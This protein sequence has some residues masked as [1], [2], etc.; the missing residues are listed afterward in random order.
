MNERPAFF[1][2]RRLTLERLEERALLDVT[3]L[4]AEQSPFAGDTWAAENVGAEDH[5]LSEM[6][7][8]PADVTPPA[9]YVPGELLIKLAEPAK[10]GKSSARQTDFIG[11]PEATESLAGLLSV[12]ATSWMEPVFPNLT[13]TDPPPESSAKGDAAS[14]DNSTPDV[15]R[16]ELARWHRVDLSEKTSVEDAIALF[17]AVPEVEIAEAN[18]QWHTADLSNLPDATTDPGFDE[19]WHHV[20]A[21]VTDTWNYL[22][23]NGVNPGGM[24]DVIV[25]VIDTG[26]DY[27]HQDLVANMWTNAGEIPDNGIDDDGNGFV[28]DVHGANVVSDPRSHSGDP[29]DLHGH[30]THV[31]GIVASTAFNELGGVGVAFNTQIMAVRAAQYSGTFAVDDIAE[32]VIY[33]IDNG[34]E[35]INMSFGGYHNSVIV[36]DALSI[37]FSRAVLVAAA[38]NSG[39]ETEYAPNVP[40]LPHYPAALPWVLGVM[41]SDS[42]GKLA[43]FSN[44]D[45]APETR[46]EYEVAAPG[47]GIYST[48]PSDRYAAWSGTS[49]ATPVVAGIAALVRSQFRDRAVYSSRFVMGQIAAN[50]DGPLGGGPGGPAPVVDAYAALTQFPSPKISLLE[51]WVFDDSAIDQ[52]NDGDGRIDAGETIHLALELMGRWGMA[53]EVT[54]TLEA[55]AGVVG[56]DPYITMIVDT[57]DF[58]A[59]GPFQTADN[60][61]IYNDEGVIVGVENPLSFSV[62]TDCPNDHVIPFVLTLTYNNAW[63]PED[64]TLYERTF[65]FSYVVQR[66]RDVPT[67]ISE[68]MELTSDDYWLIGGPVLIE[69]GATLSIR[70]GT[71][72][73][74]GGISDDPYNPGPQNGNLLVRGTLLVEGT[75]ENPVSLFPSYLVAGQVTRITVEEGA[76]GTL[77]Y[78]KVRNPEVTGFAEIDHSYFD[79]DA[80]S[81]TITA[82]LITNTIFHKLRGGAHIEAIWFDG[83]LFD[84]GWEGPREGAELYNTVFLQDNE[85]YEPFA[86]PM[87]F[88]PPLSADWQE[89]DNVQ[90]GVSIRE[91]ESFAWLSLADSTSTVAE[92]AA[93]HLG[94]HLASIRSA[95]EQQF[96][97]DFLQGGGERMHWVIGMTDDQQ[98]GTYEWLDGSPVTYT[99]WAPGYPVEL[100]STGQHLVSFASLDQGRD[101]A[102]QFQWT[103]MLEQPGIQNPWGDPQEGN[104]YLLRIPGEWTRE[105]IR[106]A[107][108]DETLI[109]QTREHHYS[110]VAQNAFLSRLWDPNL[111][112]WMRILGRA[113]SH[114]GFSTMRDNYWGTTSTT[115]ISHA[116]LDY[117]DN[118]TSA[119]IDYEAPL[120]HAVETTYPFAEQV[121]INGAPAETVPTLGA[122]PATFTVQFN[123]DMNTSIEPFVTFGPW[124][125]Y[126]DFLLDPDSGGWVDPRTWEATF[127]VNPMTGDG[128]HLMRV[129]GAVAADDPWLVT[130]YDVG[131]FRFEVETMGVAAMTLQAT[132]QEGSIGL[133]WQQDDFELLAG[134]H[135]YRAESIDGPY[136]RVNESIIPVGEEGYLDTDVTPAVP[137]YYKFTVVTTDLN[138]SDPSNVAAAAALDTILPVIGHAPATSAAAGYSLR[139]T[140]EVTD[141]VSVQSVELHYRPLGSADDYTTMAMV[142]VSGSDYSAVI[143]GSAVQTPGVDYYLTASDGISIVYDGTPAVPHGVQVDDQPTVLSVTPNQGS[144]S[145]GTHVSVSGSLFQDGAAVYF[146]GQPA[147]DVAFL[148]SSQITC[149][150]PSHFPALV[151]VTVVNP[152]ETQAARISGFRYV[153]EDAVMS[154]PEGSGDFGAFVELPLSLS[155]ADG[156]RAASATINFDPGVLSLA[157]DGITTGT[158][159]FGW[160][161]EANTATPG[162]II[163]SMASGTA[164]SGDGSLARINFEVVGAPTSQTP[165]TLADVSLNTGAITCNLDD[166]SFTVNGMFTVSGS[167]NYFGGGTVPGTMLSLAG[168][169]IHQDVSGEFGEFSMTD[170]L[171]GHYTLTPTKD[172]DAVEITSHDASLVL[173]SD[174]GMLGL[175]A[176]QMLAADVDRNGLVDA[177][178]ASYILEVAVA[179]RELPFPGAGRIWDFVPPQRSYGLI[180]SDLVGQDFTGVLIGD[181]SGNWAPGGGK[182]SGP[183]RGT[184]KGTATLTLPEIESR[185]GRRV[186]MPLQIDLGGAEVYSAD[187]VLTYDAEALSVQEVS[188]GTAAAGTSFLAN[189]QETGVIRVGLAAAQPLS[190]DGS[191]LEISFDVVGTLQDAAEVA[192]QT[193]RLNEDPVDAVQNGAVVAAGPPAVVRRRVFYNHSVFDDDDPNLNEHD[194]DA[195][196]TDKEALLPGDTATF[197]NY[198]SYSRGING[199][200]VDIAYPAAT[201]T[202]AD[203]GFRVGND[204]GPADWSEIEVESTPR[205]DVRAGE[206]DD[207]SDRV[208]IVWDD[209]V[210]Q[211]EWLQVTVLANENTGLAEDDVFYFGNAIGESGNSAIDAK[212]N[213]VD[214]VL[215][216]NNPRALLDEAPIDFCYDYNRDRRVNATDMLLARENQTH[217]LDALKLI[218]VPGANAK[219]RMTNDEEG[220]SLFLY[221]IEEVIADRRER[222][223]SS[224]AAEDIDKLLDV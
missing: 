99:N 123:R 144:Y 166:G 137:M 140:A 39:V 96:V 111:D 107:L 30:G 211:N 113:G 35:V 14:G 75:A 68:D 26:V 66:G 19:Q 102:Y 172:D 54:G 139:L 126:T 55:R 128:Y 167:M 206:G 85:L 134:Y 56:P 92:L 130:G 52:F 12:Y 171:T 32:G 151:D 204:N 179:L 202:A 194:N 221:E 132:G 112:H 41:A 2:S 150:T 143:P 40:K 37:A 16:A 76:T 175:S 89:L 38:G 28:D 71:Q 6:F 121:L 69:E 215:A 43:G 182:R 20:K 77:R 219:A 120:E 174:A 7:A 133:A 104:H 9:S 34:A 80:Y 197:A 46:Y 212:I 135:L 51:N 210:I 45:S 207:N 58:G 214:I 217:L 201:P 49:M 165:L 119:R 203:F 146:D 159:T 127:N 60:G 122:G 199:I 224:A 145:G 208:T 48:L 8:G 91:G 187:L 164:V 62:V 141:N 25:A 11:P 173:Q 23:D 109:A 149:T 95:E 216:R 90:P 78:T 74:W 161:L 170:V 198:T 223:K 87:S 86:T 189:T 73:Q 47:V 82:E 36:N 177:M 10:S 169:A 3:G 154:L 53:G 181:V 178:D 125:P 83:C 193:A 183:V 57:A 79:W 1:R 88:T 186:E 108:R 195:I 65:N 18:L 42:S 156:L 209:N 205:I 157:V 21:N 31:A 24:R 67:V 153:D 158:L 117:Y 103:N 168:T 163:L 72:V 33:A 50:V 70:E 105:G 184:S 155:G 63:D 101:P 180:N 222:Q 142:N 116:I 196:A 22:D 98:P 5:P 61:F 106:E 81:S 220:G 100:P 115:L 29:M 160:S 118:F 188:A 148:S 114:D 185:P 218:T 190:E 27:T 94:G 131:R 138:E 17:D 64:T 15:D 124:I 192:F 176:N 200:M 97:R 44:S 162:T 152:D 147:T 213:A 13:S 59:I 191:L 93:N 4:L 136:E 129:S 110:R 84:A